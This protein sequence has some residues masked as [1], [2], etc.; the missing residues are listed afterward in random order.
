MF[1]AFDFLDFFGAFRADT[2]TKSCNHENATNRP[3][4]ALNATNHP[5]GELTLGAPEYSAF[6]NPKG[7]AIC[8]NPP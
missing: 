7:E 3:L 8:L 1:A 4:G 5:L 2:F 6:F